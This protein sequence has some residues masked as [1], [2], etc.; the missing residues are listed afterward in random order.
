MVEKLPELTRKDLQDMK[1]L[2]IVEIYKPGCGPCEQL[3]PVLGEL[4][5][6]PD[7]KGKL[8]FYQSHFVNSGLGEAFGLKPDAVPMILLLQD[9]K[10]VQHFPGAKYAK[11]VSSTADLKNNERISVNSAFLGERL[12]KFLGQYYVAPTV[13]E[14]VPIQGSLEKK[15]EDPFANSLGLSPNSMITLRERYLQ[16]NEN[17]EIIETPEQMFTRIAKN[18]SQADSN[19][20]ATPEQIAETSKRFYDLM[21]SCKFM[22][23]SP[24]LMNAGR[25]L[26]QLSACFVLPVE[27]SIE[28]IFGSATKGALIHKSGGGTGYSFTNLRS[29]GARVKTTS[30]VASGP[31]SFIYAFNVYTDVVKQGGTRRGA[32]MAILEVNHADV[33]EFIHAK[34]TPNETTQKIINQYK[35]ANQLEDDDPLV[36]SL[37]KTLLE[38]TQLTNFNFSVGIIEGFMDAVK[39][40]EDY[41]LVDP[42]TKQVVKTIKAKKLLEEMV[43]QAWTTGDPGVAFLD[44]MNEYNPTPHI[45]RIEATNPCGEQPLL[46]YESCNLGSINLTKFVKK[47]EGKTAIDYDSL[48]QTVYDAV[49][50]LD[51]VIDMNKYPLKEIEDMTKGNRKI[52]LGVMGFSDVAAMLGVPYG[53][54]SSVKLAEDIM[55]FIRDEA[56]KVSTELG[57]K[58]G[59]FPNWKGSI[60]DPESKY[61]KGEELK[62]RNATLTTIAPTGT[63]SMISDC[64]SGIEP[65]FSLAYTKTVMDG[66]VL[67]YRARGL[68]YLLKERGLD[69]EGIFAELEQGKRDKFE[70]LPKE[71]KDAVKTAM[72]LTPEQHIKVQAAFQRHTDNAVSKTI[73][74]PNSAT[75]EEIY[76][77]YMLAYDAGCK[78]ITVY[79]DGC[80]DVQILEEKIDTKTKYGSKLPKERIGIIRQE[81]VGEGKTVFIPVGFSESP[82]TK[83]M[84]TQL[85]KHGTPTEFFVASNFFDAD[86][87]SLLVPL[88]V[89]NSK[90]LNEGIPLNKIVEDLKEVPPASQVGYDPGFEKGG[91]YINRS[92]PDAIWK[93]L[94]GWRPPQKNENF[95]IQKYVGEKKETPTENKKEDNNPHSNGEFGF[96]SN[97]RKYGVQRRE[98]C[99][100]CIFCEASHKGCA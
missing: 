43:D 95:K 39:K 48:K 93:A 67:H 74:F 40:D 66:K 23:N 84:I 65:F 83:R 49:H 27:D 91:E 82:M 96:C 16:K 90:D 41:K 100:K 54:D 10:V 56:R 30:G 94:T 72:I 78:G 64:E 58:R 13:Q 11:S 32:N 24:T 1:G 61:F 50:F 71:I 85:R 42:H 14:I 19:Y 35:K 92:I 76:N 17:G 34:G 44:K 2:A 57:E 3:G 5:N 81:V 73:N 55:K 45:G 47:I 25:D 62:L 46:P 69:V 75:R 26:Q 60:Y 53:S 36:E 29:K 21:A 68:E 31:V 28:G 37:T 89:R 88:A 6:H 15:I 99:D 8:E 86:T 52:G 97:C 20:G 18:I 70:A 33:Q 22:P 7:Y 80:K 38:K 63:I 59:V 87:Q 51:N 9:G 12:N 77:A 4:S 79:R 98:G